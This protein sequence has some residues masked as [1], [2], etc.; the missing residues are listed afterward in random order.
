VFGEDFGRLPSAQLARVADL[1]DLESHGPHMTGHSGYFLATA[2]AQWSGRIF[3]LG[4]RLAVS[5][6]VTVHRPSSLRRM[7]VRVHY[8]SIFILCGT[9][10][11]VKPQEVTQLWRLRV[12]GEITR[13]GLDRP[14]Q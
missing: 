4:L 13:A 2:I 6:Q 7:P 5:Y 11:R 1:C 9:P 3:C 10:Q 12:P 8:R 14:F